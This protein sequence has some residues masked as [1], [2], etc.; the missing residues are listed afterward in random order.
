VVELKNGKRIIGITSWADLIGK[1]K[2]IEGARISV[3]PYASYCAVKTGKWFNPRY[4]IHI[5]EHKEIKRICS[6]RQMVFAQ[7]RLSKGG[8][9]TSSPLEIVIPGAIVRAVFRGDEV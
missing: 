5:L 6:I 1:T 3:E 7:A 2:R 8:C 9:Y 4:R